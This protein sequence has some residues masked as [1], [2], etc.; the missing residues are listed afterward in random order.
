MGGVISHQ[1][2]LMQLMDCLI[3]LMGCFAINGCPWLDVRDMG[4]QLV[5]VLGVPCLQT[6]VTR[7]LLDLCDKNIYYHSILSQFRF[8]RSDLCSNRL[9]LQAFP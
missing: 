3:R 1:E 9:P 5:F 6:F 4:L 2:G 8:H 7:Q